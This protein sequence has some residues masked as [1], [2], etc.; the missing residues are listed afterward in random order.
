MAIVTITNQNVGSRADQSIAPQEEPIKTIPA[1]IVGVI[2]YHAN[3]SAS[4]R[5]VSRNW[6]DLTFAVIKCK[7]QE[8]LHTI[9]RI[10]EKLSP[11]KAQCIAELT[12]LQKAHQCKSQIVVS[13]PETRHLFLT[14]KGVLVGSLKK[15]SEIERDLL[16]IAIGEE[17]PDSLKDIFEISKLDLKFFENG[18]VDTFFTLLQS[19]Q[20]LSKWDRGEAVL[21]AVRDNNLELVK[22]LLADGPIYDWDRRTAVQSA[23]NNNNLELVRLLLDNGS[24]P[25]NDRVH[26]IL[27]A[28]VHMSLELVPVLTDNIQD[29]ALHATWLGVMAWLANVAR[30][31]NKSC[32]Y[33][34]DA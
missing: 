18:N 5:L 20:P 16:Q 17:L 9:P 21:P 12:Q 11:D 26:A 6:N 34:K 7:N 27:G 28:T 3:D 25:Y 15:L 4:T 22:V 10:I 24:I 2:L 23:E 31:Y 32:L 33:G 14:N 1:E 13:F 19:C 30:C 29:L 8:L